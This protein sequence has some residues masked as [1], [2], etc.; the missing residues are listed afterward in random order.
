MTSYIAPEREHDDERMWAQRK[1]ELEPSGLVHGMP[2]DEY[3]AHPTSL[4]VS[5]A[6]T[7]LKSPARFQWERQNP[8]YKDVFDF[9]SV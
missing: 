9:G 2:E 3:H 8:V 1:P 5:G 6:K 7:L 4:S